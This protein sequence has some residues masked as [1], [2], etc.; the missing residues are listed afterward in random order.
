MSNKLKIT[1]LEHAPDKFEI[2]ENY[3]KR[4]DN[5]NP[6][7]MPELSA[8]LVGIKATFHE[9]VEYAQERYKPRDIDIWWRRQETVWLET[10]I[11]PEEAF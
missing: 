5:G 6:F 1:I 3:V 4:E 10:R 7:L 2:I 8:D 9:A 11:K